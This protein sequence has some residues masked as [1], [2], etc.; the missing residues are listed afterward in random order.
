MNHVQTQHNAAGA[1]NSVVVTF[2]APCAKDNLIVVAIGWDNNARSVTSVV[3]NKGNTYIPATVKT[4]WNSGGDSF[5]V[6]YAS[7]IIGGGAAI[8][9]TI[10]LDGAATSYL[11]TFVT[12]AE[13]LLTLDRSIVAVGVSGTYDTGNVTTLLP[14]EYLWGATYTYSPANA[15]SNFTAR[16]T[17]NGNRIQDRLVTDIGTYKCTGTLSASAAWVSALITFS[18]IARYR[19]RKI[20][21]RQFKP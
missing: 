12:E 7:R 13:G 5:H 14:D 10:T 17:V 21:P 15:D 8:A 11:E 9:I 20:R 19:P 4:A 2:A 16:S 6:Y 1:T 3:D 18:G